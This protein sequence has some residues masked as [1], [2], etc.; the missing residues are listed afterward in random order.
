MR[1]R[2]GRGG[3]CILLVIIGLLCHKDGVDRP[4]LHPTPC[5][6]YSGSLVY[7][8]RLGKARYG[9]AR[10]ALVKL[11]HRMKEL[12]EKKRGILRAGRGLGMELHR[13]QRPGAVADA[14][15]RTIVQ[16][17]KPGVPLFRQRL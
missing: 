2:R 13:A 7:A 8:R 14:F 4:T 1:T 3:L 6:V 16:V 5:M 9:V 15:V 10:E 11:P 12:I 17:D